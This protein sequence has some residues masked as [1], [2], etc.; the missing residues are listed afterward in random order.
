MFPI[1]L[2]KTDTMAISAF[3]SLKFQVLDLVNLSRDAV[4]M[5]VGIAVF[6]FTVAIR[7][8]EGMDWLC[9]LPVYALAVST[10][11]LDLRDCLTSLGHVRW[12]AGIHDILNTVFWPTVMVSY[13]YL[14]RKLH[15]VNSGRL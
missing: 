9:L 6:L 1:P 7:K 15:D 12:S 2:N 11:L 3:Q 4:H 5:H 14:S 8:K 10:E 13:A